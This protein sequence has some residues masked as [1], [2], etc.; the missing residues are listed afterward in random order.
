MTVQELLIYLDKQR[1]E[2]NQKKSDLCK[3]LDITP[4]SYWRIMQG[5]QEI[6]ALTLFKWVNLYDLDVCLCVK[7]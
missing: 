6:S 1:H 5:K 3:Q 7:T 4:V 2:R